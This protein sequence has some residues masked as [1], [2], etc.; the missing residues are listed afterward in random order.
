MPETRPAVT[1]LVVAT[2][3]TGVAAGL[4]GMLLALLLHLVQHLAYGYGADS[5][6][7]HA[8]F[9][10]GVTMAGGMRRV[11]VLAGCGLVAGL[12]W[13]A[14][15]H[16][17]RKLVSVKQAAG[18]GAPA[19]PGGATLAHAL[20]QI[21]TVAL[22]SPLGREVAPREIGALLAGY[23]ARWTGLTVEYRRLLVACG[24]GAGLAA[25]YNV[26]L[27]GAVFVLE[28]LVG[29]FSWPVAAM[30]MASSALA[31]WVAWWGLGAE[32]QYLVPHMAVTPA[33]VAWA[34][35]LGPLFGVAAHGFA[36]LTGAARA[37]AARG[38]RLAA[39]SLLNFT[40]IGLLAVYLP[41]LL[42]N[43]K[44]A[45]S[46]SF[47]GELTVGVAAL[48]LVL[49][50]AIEASTLRA[51][52]EGGLLTPGLT[53]GALLAFIAGGLCN[54][55]LPGVFGAVPLGAY[56]IV[57]ATAF[58]ASSMSMP[59]TAIVLLAEFTRMDHDMLVPVVLAVAGSACA[60]RWCAKAAAKPAQVV[61]MPVPVSASAAGAVSAASAVAPR[62]SAQHLARA[63]KTA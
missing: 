57:G 7:A 3:S 6:S 20:L 49:K 61:A 38:W 58:L 15:Y 54:Q 18:P 44:G 41:Q 34:L 13:W 56:A 51:G 23:L 55:L 32:S 62:A 21:V 30:A 60:S 42:G 27:G 12:G 5:A 46:L 36:R 63:D 31:A 47:D 28:V 52:A 50:V 33:L 29:A 1:A 10:Q 2:L 19:M 59:L 43:G 45:A 11:L 25:V 8:S 14:V 48:L 24:A 4:G 37:R 22:G 9:L 39:L 53:N 16:H 26:P 35:V 40:V 17:G